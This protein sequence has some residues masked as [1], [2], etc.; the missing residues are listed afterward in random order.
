[1]YPLLV[2]A[3]V[4]L[5]AIVAFSSPG[6]SAM[7]WIIFG[8]F[9]LVIAVVGFRYFFGVDVIAK[10]QGVATP[11]PKIDLTVVS[12]ASA[13]SAEVFHVPG[14]YTYSDA[15]ALCRAYGGKLANIDQITSAYEKG[16][17]WCDYGWSDENM[18]LFP[19]QKKTWALF[20]DGDGGN[21]G[22]DCGRPGV[23]GGY[24][25]NLQQR[26][27][28]NCYAPKPPQSGPI[29]PLVVPPKKGDAKTQYYT[30]HPPAVSPFNYTQWNASEL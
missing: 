6:Y 2:V 5:V 28:A 15:Q 19:T 23:N 12:S 3:V 7:E 22:Q 29:Q 8:F 17:D 18:A 24:N 25:N 1:M 30:E 16:A 10:I 13:P 21:H 14:K 4:G 26:L 27:G 9:L 20:N 11:K